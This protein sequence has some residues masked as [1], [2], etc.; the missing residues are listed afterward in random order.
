MT[1]EVSFSCPFKIFSIFHPKIVLMIVNI[2]GA[3]FEI[4]TEEPE[5]VFMIQKQFY[6]TFWE[7]KTAYKEFILYIP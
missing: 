7:L 4:N 2:F 3:V 6:V 1:Q 5:E